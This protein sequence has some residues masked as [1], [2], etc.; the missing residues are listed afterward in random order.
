MMETVPVKGRLRSC[1]RAAHPAEAAE[2]IMTMNARINDC[3][4]EDGAQRA[5]GMASLGIARD[6]FNKSGIRGVGRAIRPTQIECRLGKKM[7]HRCAGA[8]LPKG[9][10]LEKRP[11]PPR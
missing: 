7:L 8:G 2:F 1:M 6:Q 4:A 5:T 9:P 11:A 3:T 10:C